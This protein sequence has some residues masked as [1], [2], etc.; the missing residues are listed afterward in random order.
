MTKKDYELLA[1]VIG[2]S[3]IAPQEKVIITKEICE[4]LLQ[5]NCR[6]NADKFKQKV[7]SWF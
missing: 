1:D 5:Q 7:L 3:E 6:F 2:M 4:A